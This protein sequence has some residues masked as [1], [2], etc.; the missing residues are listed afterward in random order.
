MRRGW[1]DDICAVTPDVETPA[2]LPSAWADIT[3]GVLEVEVP[4]AP[5][6]FDSDGLRQASVLVL[7]LFKRLAAVAF[8]VDVKDNDAAD[9][10]GDDRD[11]RL[12]IVVEPVA[13]LRDR[14][15][16]LLV[17]LPVHKRPLVVANRD[18]G[19]LALQVAQRAG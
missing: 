7:Q 14:R 17:R 19:P 18:D 13:H 5:A 8:G 11:P 10:A 9:G 12:R 4:A 2:Q 1:S 3:A 6:C 15:A 16:A